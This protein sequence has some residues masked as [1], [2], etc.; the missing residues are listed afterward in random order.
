MRIYNAAQLIYCVPNYLHKS[1]TIPAVAI[2]SA[3]YDTLIERVPLPLFSV[4]LFCDSLL[5][6]VNNATEIRITYETF[7][8]LRIEFKTSGRKLFKE[9][10][11]KT[12]GNWS[13]R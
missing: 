5:T 9:M 7:G 3:A 13:H 2:M 8:E 11:R 6:L 10:G 1:I 4:C 12:N